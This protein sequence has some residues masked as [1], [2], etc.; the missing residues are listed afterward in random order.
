MGNFGYSFPNRK[1]MGNFGYKWLFL[2]NCLFHY[3][4]MCGN[5]FSLVKLQPF[6]EFNDGSNDITLVYNSVFRLRVVS[7]AGLFE[8]PHGNN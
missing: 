8:S 7:V 6:L 5:W 4:L 1:N 2:P 3:K